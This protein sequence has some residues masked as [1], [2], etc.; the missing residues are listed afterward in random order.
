MVIF[1]MGTKKN[2]SINLKRPL[3]KR[4][5]RKCSPDIRLELEKLLPGLS[6]QKIMPLTNFLKLYLR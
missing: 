5:F 3:I 4:E 2:S 1:F 6:E